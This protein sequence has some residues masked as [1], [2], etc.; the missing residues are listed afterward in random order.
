MEAM[1]AAGFRY[2]VIVQGAYEQF[3]PSDDMSK[4]LAEAYEQASRAYFV[5][6]ANLDLSRRQF[7]TSFRNAKVV[8]NPFNVA[9]DAKPPWPR[10]TS[11]ELRLACVGRLDVGT[12][13]QDLLL[14]VLALPHWRHR[15]VRISLVG[16]GENENI[17]RQ[18]AKHLQLDNVCLEGH[19]IDIEDVWRRHHGL[20]LPSRCEG[21]PLVIVEAMI[22]ARPCIVT[23]VGGNREL[24]R[25]D[26]NGFLAKGPSVELLDEALNRAWNARGRLMEIGQIAA[27]DVR[28]WVAEDPSEY[29]VQDLEAVIARDRDSGIA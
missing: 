17:I 9:Y 7:G 29:F 20:V 3:W 12:K 15:R 24:I 1:R 13:G 16:K 23:D 22:C 19:V 21:M 10:D 25:D 11:E 18:L 26:I 6:E 28:A 8:R 2:A 14:Q 4:R 27:R 5:S